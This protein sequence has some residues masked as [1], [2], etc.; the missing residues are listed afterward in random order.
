M[1]K[2]ESL[3]LSNQLCFLVYRIDREINGHYRSFLRK[4]NLTYPQY[5]VMLVLWEEDK[6][7]IGTICSRLKLDT[8]TISPL[9]RRLELLGFVYRERSELDGRSYHIC[10]TE[11]G[12]K[13]REASVDIPEGMLGCMSLDLTE[14]EEV[15]VFL[16]DLLQKVEK[17]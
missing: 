1:D 6:L 4:L 16:E 7:P 11:A 5:L 13:L 8:G 15:K 12:K 10:L 9:L 17:K 14:Y 3:K 2:Y